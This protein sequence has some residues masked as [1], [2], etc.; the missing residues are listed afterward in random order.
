[1]ALPGAGA[2]SQDI[3]NSLGHI[4]VQGTYDVS[5]LYSIKLADRPNPGRYI[6]TIKYLRRGPHSSGA[7]GSTIE[8][9]DIP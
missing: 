2:S 6:L 8:M 9:L 3:L 1:M 7:E 5:P 4:I